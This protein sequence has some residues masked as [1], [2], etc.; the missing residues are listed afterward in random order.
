MSTLLKIKK[1]LFCFTAEVSAVTFQQSP[2][3]VKEKTEVQ[4]NCSHDDANLPLMSWYQQRKGSLSMTFLGFGYATAEPTN[5]GRLEEQFQLRR[6]SMTAGTLTVHSANLSHSGVYYC[7]AST[8]STQPAYFGKGTK[9]TVLDPDRQITPPKV[10]IFR[11]SPK[12]CKNQKEEQ[13]KKTLVCVAS[14]FYPDH[15]TVSWKLNGEDVSTGVATDSA[16]TPVDKSYRITSRLKI[17]ATLWENQ[18]NSFVCIVSFFDGDTTI[19]RNDT[20][21]VKGKGGGITR[22]EYLNITQGAKLSYVVVII[23]SCVY[24]L[25]VGFLVWKL[26]GSS[27]KHK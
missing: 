14:D 6:Q 19:Y 11:P 15:V 5:E 8:H 2:Q 16:A 1:V 21:D 9:L 10:K 7:A 3:V 24:G 17:S 12:E 27:G 23:K 4:I 26:Q 20:L 25:F 13:R 18:D 22:G